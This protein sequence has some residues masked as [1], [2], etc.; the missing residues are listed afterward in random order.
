MEADEFNRKFHPIPALMNLLSNSPKT[1]KVAAV[2]ETLDFGDSMLIDVHLCT[3][4]AS[5]LP[6][7]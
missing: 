3:L 7:L 6:D 1:D 2:P 4:W 5:L